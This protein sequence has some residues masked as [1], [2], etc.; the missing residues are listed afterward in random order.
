MDGKHG[1]DGKPGIAVM[2]LPAANANLLG[3]PDFNSPHDPSRNDLN[4]IRI[5]HGPKGPARP[6]GV[7]AKASRR[8]AETV[9]D[10][11]TESTTIMAKSADLDLKLLQ[12]G[13]IESAPE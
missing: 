9:R 10:G 1:E 3:K 8:S 12:S 2:A 6:I 13:R 11:G 5:L 4:Q 7:S